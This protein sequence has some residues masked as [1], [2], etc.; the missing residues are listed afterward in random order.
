MPLN[1]L[2]QAGLTAEEA[3]VFLWNNVKVGACLIG[4]KR[5]FLAVNNH[6]CKLLEYSESELLSKKFD[7]ILLPLDLF[8]DIKMMDKLRSGDHNTYEMYQTYVTKTQNLT[9]LQLT[10]CPLKSKEG[11]I[12]YF[13]SQIAEYKD[14]KFEMSPIPVQVQNKEISWKMWLYEH[15][16][17]IILGICALIGILFQKSVDFEVLKKE[18][19]KLRN[20]EPPAKVND[21]KEV[22]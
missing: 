18:V 10:V 21:I 1:F 3:F 9:K 20:N 14:E 5:E 8:H 15:A 22:P 6:F 16:W 17:K 13:L 2:K 4:E 7:D 12:L 11:K 19:E